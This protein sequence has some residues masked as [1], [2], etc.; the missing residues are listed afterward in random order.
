[1]IDLSQLQPEEQLDFWL[2]D[3]DVSWGDDQQG[4]NT[5]TRILDSRVIQ[6]Q[7]DG[8]PALDFRGMSLSVYNPRLGLWRQTWVDSEGNYWDFRGGMQGNE[9][10]LSTDDVVEGQPVKLRMV[11]YNI[12][13]EEL[14]WRWE[15]SGDDGRTWQL[16]WHIHYRRK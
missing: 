9:M 5:I 8:A 4:R 15:R 12:A 6:E 16:Q 7:F 1:M 11:F 13:E 2:G 14:D 10:I 3:W